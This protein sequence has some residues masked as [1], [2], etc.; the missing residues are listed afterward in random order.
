VEG[1]GDQGG[2][3]HHDLEHE[4][5]STGSGQ[6]KGAELDALTEGS[7]LLSQAAYGV[8]TPATGDDVEELAGSD[9]STIWVEQCW[10]WDRSSPS[11]PRRGPGR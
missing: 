6:I 9:V 5:V 8:G 2:I 3:A 10:R 4:P 11:A 1:I 7:R